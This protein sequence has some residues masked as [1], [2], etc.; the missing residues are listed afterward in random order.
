MMNFVERMHA[1]KQYYSSTM[2]AMNWPSASAV[3]FLSSK[4]DFSKVHG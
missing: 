3:S 4:S 1:A 2:H